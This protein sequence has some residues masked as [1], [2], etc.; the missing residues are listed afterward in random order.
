M[1]RRAN[2]L[3]CPIDCLTMAETVDRID[4]AIRSGACL[5]HV[6][7][8]AAKLVHMQSDAELRQSVIASDLINA[9][10]QA[11][12]W[13]AN[14]LGQPLPERVAGIDLRE[15][16]VGLAHRNGYKIFFF[17]ATEDVVRQV[18]ATYAEAYSPDIIAGCRNGYYRKDEE[19]TIAAQIRD[20]GAH[21]LFIAI[22]SPTKE[23]FLNTYKD[24]LKIP[25]IRGVGG[26]FDVVA[27]K[28]RRAPHWMQNYGLEWFYRFLQEPRR[29][30][31]R[32]LTTNT[33]FI[34]F[35][36]MAK[37]CVNLRRRAADRDPD[38]PQASREVYVNKKKLKK[39]DLKE[40]DKVTVRVD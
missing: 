13:A 12:V 21:I 1:R 28:V 33:L 8:N 26:N 25:F 11:V 27:G 30:W 10:G 35:V 14:F 37:C 9:D 24:V 29:M 18:V 22:S 40:G 34:W 36:M 17:G 3:G 20:S 23:I 6:V 38:D 31:R 16:L 15:E 39:A 7:V 19:A 2:F 32:Y 4:T 5:Q